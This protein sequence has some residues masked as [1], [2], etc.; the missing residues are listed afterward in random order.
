VTISIVGRAESTLVKIQDNGCG[1]PPDRINDR[2]A[3]GLLGM[4]ERAEMIG[5]TLTI[6]SMPGKSTTVSLV[7]HHQARAAR[8]KRRS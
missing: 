8:R 7:L 3:L 5:G 4:R 6:T 1:M 2:A